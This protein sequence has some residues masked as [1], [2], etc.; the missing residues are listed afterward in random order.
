MLL[1]THALGGGIG[2]T[3]RA[4]IGSSFAKSAQSRSPNLGSRLICY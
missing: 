3:V 2:S 4:G 1:F